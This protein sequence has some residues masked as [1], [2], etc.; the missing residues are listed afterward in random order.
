MLGVSWL[1]LAAA[2]MSVACAG[3]AQTE[4]KLTAREL[5][6]TPVAQ[7]EKPAAAPKVKKP[8]V[9]PDRTQPSTPVRNRI[10]PVKPP[11]ME[12][13]QAPLQMVSMGRP[14][15]LRY[16][17]LKASADGSYAEVDPEATFR[18]GDSIRVRVEANDN[19]H[20][21]IVQQG[22]SKTWNL[23]F[24][25]EETENGNNR[26]HPDREYTIPAGARFTFDEQPGTER[27]FIILSR[28]PEPDMEKLIYNLSTSPSP[29]PPQEK[30]MLA[31]A[32]PIDDRVIAGLRTEMIARDLV[33]E[34]VDETTP[35]P[36]KETAMYVATQDGS[37]DAR[38]V[39]DF[40][41]K[42]R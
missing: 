41:L 20:L 32:R 3:M 13:G 24:P 7:A 29:E 9:K 12:D 35:G 2:A 30:L 4:H 18:S 31:A 15:A 14:L 34:K 33:F 22:S 10:D 6:Y 42:H 21:Y 26:I 23:L 1:R 28:R 8:P 37:T 39:V 40:N 16:S 19:S 38:I 17:I 5:F 27:L 25:N 11:P 36:K